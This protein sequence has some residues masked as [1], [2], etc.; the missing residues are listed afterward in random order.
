MQSWLK[1]GEVRYR[2]DIVEGIERTV[3]AFQGLLT[4]RNRGKLIVKVGADPTLGET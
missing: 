4:G 3:E 1:S 2:E